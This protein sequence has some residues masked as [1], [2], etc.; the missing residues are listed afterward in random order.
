M[1]YFGLDFNKV[2]VMKVFSAILVV[3]GTV[4]GSGFMSGKEIVVF[5]SRFG[6]L[7]FPCIGLCF[8]LFFLLFDF[9]LRHGE[10]AKERLKNSKFSLIINFFICTILSAAMIAGCINLLSSFHVLIKIAI[11]GAILIYCVSVIRKGMGSLEKAN[12]A[13]VPVMII[14]LIIALSISIKSSSGVFHKAG[15]Y[16]AYS[17]LYSILYVLLNTSNSCIVLAKVGS[18][19]TDKQKVRVSF[20]SAL[21]LSLILLFANFVL[22]QN[23][24]VF[25]QD[26]PLLSLFKGRGA[27]IMQMIIMLGC[28]TTLFS[29][30]LT[31]AESVR[32]LCNKT[33][34]L[35]LVC[36][37]IPLGISLCG[38][39]NIV[40]LLYPLTSV[41]GVFLLC[42]L[43]MIPFFK[44]T[45][46]KIHSRRK[47][48]K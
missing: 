11:I 46:A 32:G 10:E 48:A 47:N 38:F 34:F 27:F 6:W 4:I 20:F 29:L 1:Q 45:Y 5:F 37:I 25:G 17:I 12:L 22:L 21:A 13:L 26:M 39:G 2:I 24:S 7:S 3:I 18:K 33:W 8:F 19:M 35:G 44:R 15:E 36:L 23:E 31:N 14:V 40:S 41:L 42:D 30:V 16:S 43:F 9:F 28:V